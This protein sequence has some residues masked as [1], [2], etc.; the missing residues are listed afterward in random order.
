MPFFL[1]LQKLKKNGLF[2]VMPRH[3]LGGKENKVPDFAIEI[4]RYRFVWTRISHARKT[5]VLRN[6]L[7]CKVEEKSY[8]INTE[9]LIRHHFSFS[10][11]LSY[12]RKAGKE[13]ALFNTEWN[14]VKVSH[15]I[16]TSEKKKWFD[17]TSFQPKSRIFI[18]EENNN[19]ALNCKLK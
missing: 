12:Q 14:R 6:C 9:T 17:C 11:A 16:Y 19:G 2:T 10:L 4:W 18:P 3:I 5:Q 1:K 15:E 7:S 8:P 13:G